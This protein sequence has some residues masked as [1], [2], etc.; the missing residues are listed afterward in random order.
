MGKALSYSRRQ[1]KLDALGRS[2]GLAQ[3]LRQLGDVGRDAPVLI[4]A[5]QLWAWEKL[6][7]RFT[8]PIGPV[9]HNRP[10]SLA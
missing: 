10:R 8:Q 2:S 5:E 9:D 6:A 7:G 1:I 4:F 3:Q